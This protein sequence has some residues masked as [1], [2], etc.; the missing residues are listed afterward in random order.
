M[1]TP[2]FLIMNFSRTAWVGIVAGLLLRSAL[3]GGGPQNVLVVVNDRD[4]ASMEL[5]RYYMEKRGIPE[6]NLC[7][8]SLV[9]PGPS[10]LNVFFDKHIRQ[11][12]QAHIE[13]QKLT[14]QIDFLVLCWD[15]PS[16]ISEQESITAA[17]SYGFKNAPAAPPCALLPSTSNTYFSAERAFTHSSEG[18]G[19]PNYL[20]MI[21]TARSPEEARRLV[22]RSVSADGTAP[23]GTFY[24]FNY[25]GDPARNVRFRFV[26]E[27]DSQARFLDDFPRCVYVQG[28]L[29]EN[30]KD[31]MGYQVGLSGYPEAFWKTNTFLP[32]AIA[33]H[34]TS[35]GGQLPTPALGQS[36]VLDWIGAGA[37]ASYGTV[38]EPC[39]FPE[40]FPGPMVYFWYARGFNL[41]ESYWMSVSHPHQGL[42]VGDPLMA[43]Y[44]RPA[45][46]TIN[47]LE[48]GQTISGV[49]TVRVSAAG[50]LE[51]PIG[52][53]DF[54]LDDLFVA[55]L[56]NVPPQA[57]NEIH[58]NIDGQSYL[59]ILD[60]RDTLFTAADGLA[61]E[62]KRYNPVLNAVPLGDRLLLMDGRIGKTGSSTPVRVWMEA[63]LGSPPAL[64]VRALK[65]AFLDGVY[66]A[67]KQ[68]ALRGPANEGDA[69][70]CNITL[71]DS[72]EVPLRV[73]A[74]QGETTTSLV[75]RLAE[76]IRE[77]PL[78]KTQAGVTLSW[79]RPS[80]DQLEFAI[81]ANEKGPRGIALLLKYSIR[82]AQAHSGLGPPITYEG[83]LG[84]N[85]DLLCSRGML[86]FACGWEALSTELVL[87]TAT[88]PDGPHTLRFVARDGTAL[89]TQGHR[90]LHL[91]TSNRPS[92]PSSPP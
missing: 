37:S 60:D 43:P 42:F 86:Q 69:I 82:P 3:A 90:I 71:A 61:R 51:R 44:A 28:G 79:G 68:L 63:G 50:T 84:D 25:G 88:W 4:K 52:A 48:E 91:A 16:R 29:R 46:V 66:P 74:N 21:L 64:S 35:F 58:A 56:T 1:L 75:A 12:I 77:H 13:K 39:N 54:Y 6:R 23:K 85:I 9:A 33:D 78:L 34:L 38:N 72:N 73:V 87:D 11:P 81:E 36:S 20:A 41:A 15:A 57:W 92:P 31:V 30:L 24:F 80:G 7:R 10:L 19:R 26:E 27:F 17:L 5:G 53:V 59:Y 2:G 65:P 76:Q 32:G 40:K 18:G 45:Q 8:I 47:G 14:N 55:T 70:E 67:R 22:D 49:V 83:R 89:Q 62:I